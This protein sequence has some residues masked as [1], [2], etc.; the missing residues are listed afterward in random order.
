MVTIPA[1]MIAFFVQFL[2]FPARFRYWS[3]AEPELKR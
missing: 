3:D 2:G 1:S